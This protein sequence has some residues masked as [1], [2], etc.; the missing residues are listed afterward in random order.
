MD[1]RQSI[2]KSLRDTEHNRLPN[3]K[4]HPIFSEA[5]QKKWPEPFDFPTGLSVKLCRIEQAVQLNC[6]IL[7]KI[8]GFLLR[9]YR[10]E[11][12]VITKGIVHITLRVN[13]EQTLFPKLLFYAL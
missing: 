2:S 7:H 3:F 1:S 6:Q 4:G 12:I 8:R 5:Y 11:K 9:I 10:E 13:T